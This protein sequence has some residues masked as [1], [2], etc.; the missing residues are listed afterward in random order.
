MHALQIRNSLMLLSKWDALHRTIETRCIYTYNFLREW[1][2]GNE[3]GHF[4]FHVTR[5]PKISSEKGHYVC[6]IHLLCVVCLNRSVLQARYNAH[7]IDPSEWLKAI[8]IKLSVCVCVCVLLFLSLVLQT[9]SLSFS[10]SIY[11]SIYLLWSFAFNANLNRTLSIW[12][13]TKYL[14]NI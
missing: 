12:M 13:G 2:S 5:T 14:E 3:N 1:W 4:V 8:H 11:L 10:S 9:H 7:T 6:C